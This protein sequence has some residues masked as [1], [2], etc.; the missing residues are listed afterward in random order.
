MSENLEH[1]WKIVQVPCSPG[2][3]VTTTG[4]V[5]ARCGGRASYPEWSSVKK[6]SAWD[7]SIFRTP[8]FCI[9]K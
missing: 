8:E 9:Q 2:S 7:R 4:F 6:P 3:D 1:N 5:C